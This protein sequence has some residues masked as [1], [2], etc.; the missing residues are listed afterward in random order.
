MTAKSLPSLTP[1]LPN[2]FNDD[3]RDRVSP[4][5]VF[6]HE[7]RDAM[8]AVVNVD[9]PFRIFSVTGVPRCARA[10]RP[11]NECAIFVI[12]LTPGVVGN[13]VVAAAAAPSTG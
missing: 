1:R 2:A 4:V 3:L 13:S 8:H 11:G 7:I 5:M 6:R 12:D 9:D 10:G